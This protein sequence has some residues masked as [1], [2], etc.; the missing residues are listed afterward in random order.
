MLIVGMIFIFII[1]I[2]IEVPKLIKDKMWGEV[3]AFSGLLLFG[4]VL[5]IAAS[6]Q[7]KVPNPTVLTEMIFGP[8]SKLLISIFE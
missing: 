2:L 5:S 4:M 7:V 3:M 1:I 6:L 8:P